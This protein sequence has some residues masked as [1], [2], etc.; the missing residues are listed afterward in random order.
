MG[1]LWNGI[2]SGAAL[3][4]T[5]GGCAAVIFGLI[6]GFVAG[7]IPGLNGA[8]A[9]ACVLPFAPTFGAVN[10]RILIISVYAGTSFGGYPR[11][12]D[13]YTG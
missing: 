6:L 10:S 9:M 3:L 11:D 1:T 5:P 7:V 12:T 8:N 13:E 4:M 2:G